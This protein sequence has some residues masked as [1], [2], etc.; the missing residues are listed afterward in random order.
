MIVRYLSL[1]L[2]LLLL[3][4]SSGVPGSY[5]TA[6]ASDFSIFS[7]PPEGDGPWV[8]RATY[9]DPQ[10][11]SELPSRLEPW[12]VHPEEGYLVAEVDREL[13][14]WMQSIGFGLQVD[15]ALTD[16]IRQ[17]AVWSPY[18]VSGIPNYPCYRTVEETYTTAENIALSYPNLASWLDIGDSWEKTYPGGDQGYDL[19]VLRLTNSQIAGP[20]PGLFVMSG[21]HAREYAPVELNT[22]FAEYLVENYAIDPDVTWLL[23]YSEVHLLLQANPDGRKKAESGLSW[24]KNTDNLYCSDPNSRGV[25]LNRNFSFRWGCCNGSSTIPCDEVYRGPAASSEPET[26]AIQSYLRTHFPD[27]RQDDLDAPAPADAEGI[28]LDL[29]S[30]GQL[31]LWPWGFT[32][33]DAPNGNTLQTL[34]RKFAYFNGYDPQ[35]SDEL[36][37]TDGTSDDFA[38][39]E[40]GLA[41]YTF[42]VGNAFFQRCNSFE[43]QVAPDNLLALIYAAKT[44]RRP[45]QSPAG[46]E[47]LNLA[48]NPILSATGNPLQISAIIDDTRFSA[49]GGTEPTQNIA[50]A[51]ISLDAPPWSVTPP[52]LTQPLIPADGGFDEKSEMVIATLATAGLSSGRHIAFVRGRDAAGNWGP[53]SALFFNVLNP[54]IYLP[55]IFTSS[56]YNA[57]SAPA[58]I[59]LT[60]P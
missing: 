58:G 38:Y 16:Q 48:I 37:P 50:A 54:Y 4:S 36:Y 56:T 55:M 2:L 10:M 44:A 22:R 5:P 30:Y 26:H 31:V 7:G 46:P 19:Y 41:T 18:Q 51:E 11:V 1:S 14:L 8:V 47:A 25:D 39:G 24:R 60:Q 52:A 13:Y 49:L 53:P 15:A 12:E 42:E 34:G 29:H 17:P 27:Q 57:Q 6:F 21:L 35:Q 32:S 9:S 43:S 40:L 3:L 33:Q 28:F 59:P 20:K 23:D 45:Y